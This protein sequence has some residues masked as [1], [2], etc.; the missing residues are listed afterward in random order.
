MT[1]MLG[2]TL[3]IYVPSAS[4]DTLKQVGNDV[5]PEAIRH[6]SEGVSLSQEE[7]YPE[8]LEAYDQALRYKEDSPETWYNKGVVLGRLMKHQEALEAYEQALKYRADFSDALHN[9]GVI[10]VQLGRG[11]EASGAFERV[12]QLGVKEADLY[13]GWATA[14]LLHGLEGLFDQN[15]RAF[16]EAVLKYIDILEKAQQD[17]MG[18]VVGEALTR[19]KAALEV[20]AKEGRVDEGL[21]EAIE[22]VEL[23]IRLLSIK[24]P[25]EGARALA[26]ELSR[27][28]PEGVTA[29]E[30]IREQ[31]E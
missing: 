1:T 21:L 26:K 19:S 8:A 4:M 12:Y 15:I 11:Q 31:R 18:R 2:N 22:E 7:K 16:E 14:S 23:G 27:V 5:P 20:E 29:E 9:K 28:W 10:L 24:D 13:H 6:F 25:F 30:A 17:G 3:K